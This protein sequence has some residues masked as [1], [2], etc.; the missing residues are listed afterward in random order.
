MNHDILKKFILPQIGRMNWEGF[1]KD[2]IGSIMSL[3]SKFL[4]YIESRNADR[5][6]SYLAFCMQEWDAIDSCP[7][8]RKMLE[9]AARIIEQEKGERNGR[10]IQ[11]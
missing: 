8:D 2:N 9:R 3:Q 11:E 4:K 6:C 10:I 7:L 5:L 1:D